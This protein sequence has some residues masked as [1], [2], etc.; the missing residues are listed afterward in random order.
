MFALFPSASL[1]PDLPRQTPAPV[2]RIRRIYIREPNNRTEAGDLRKGLIHQ[3]KKSKDFEVVEA[4]SQADAILA[5]D[6]QIYIR[7]YYSL[8]AR[9]GTSPEHGRPLY[10]GYVS[11]ELKSPSGETLWS[12]LSTLPVESNDP[13]PWLSKDIVKHLVTGTASVEKSN[14]Q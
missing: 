11:A 13:A 7:G 9:A 3:L 1:A 5:I 12:Y 4:P 10:G 6:P 8:Y 14:K 2:Q